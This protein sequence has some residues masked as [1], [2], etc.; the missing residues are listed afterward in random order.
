VGEAEGVTWVDDS[1]ATNPHAADAAL[2]G[3]EHLVWVAGGLAKGAGPAEFDELVRTHAQRLRAAVLIGLDREVIGGALARHAPEIPVVEV[4]VPDTG[5]MGRSIDAATL[6]D[7]VVAT[8]AD[9]ARPG[10]TVLLA[11]ACASMDQFSSYAHRG[12]AFADAVRR[13]LGPHPATGS[14]G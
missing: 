8:A 1:K 14:G 9:L 11:P 13:R 5:G 12:N 6:M 3:F 2:G 10:D 4:D 7:V